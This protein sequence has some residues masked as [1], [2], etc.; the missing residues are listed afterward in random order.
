MGVDIKL[1]KPN[2]CEQMHGQQTKISLEGILMYDICNWWSQSQTLDSVNRFKSL[3]PFQ[4]L[5]DV[6]II[7]RGCWCC[8]S[9]KEH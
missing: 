1:D 4:E 6:E 2:A 3:I 7:G 5:F 9:M 8:P